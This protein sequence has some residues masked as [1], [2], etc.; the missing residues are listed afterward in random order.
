MRLRRNVLREGSV[1]QYNLD[2]NKKGS[3]KTF[4]TRLHILQMLLQKIL[5]KLENIKML[6]VLRVS[7]P[8]TIRRRRKTPRNISHRIRSP[9][10]KTR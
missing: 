9:R 1:N 4:E 7:G 10:T 5:V 8:N 2:K 6:S 3:I